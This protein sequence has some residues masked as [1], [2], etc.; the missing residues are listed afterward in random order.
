MQLVQRVQEILL[1]PNE[2]WSAI[3][4]ESGDVASIYKNYLIY[5]ALIPAVAGFI[6]MSLV[7][8]GGF[9]FSMRVPI[10]SGL[11]SM[12]VGY[13]LSLVMVFVISLIANALAPKFGGEQNPLNAFKLVAYGSTAGFVGGI[14]SL[15]PSL[16]MLGILASLYSI[17][18][19]YTGVPTLMKC[20][21]DKSMAYTAVL[22]VCG[23]VAGI[24]LGA[25]S[26]AFHTTPG[27]GNA[28]IEGGAPAI[29]INTPEGSVQVN[30]GNGSSDKPGIS[31]TTPKGVV[32]IDATNMEAMA[33]QMAEVAKKMEEAQA[34]QNGK[35]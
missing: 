33:K 6:G 23:V 30:A 18:L 2:T 13:V 34:A 31:I 21:A 15:L 16:S 22:I 8:Y 3:A 14:F 27:F 29:S 28:A 32:Q 35:K 5:L 7:G 26:A 4:G 11:V 10:V 17:Y 20:P 12:V 24:I 1:K 19:I 9:G 25:V